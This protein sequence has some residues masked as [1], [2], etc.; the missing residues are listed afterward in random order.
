MKYESKEFHVELKEIV[1]PDVTS[2]KLKNN[3]TDNPSV[4]IRF[5][6]IEGIDEYVIV[7]RSSSGVYEE[8]ATISGNSYVDNTVEYG[9]YYEYM[10]LS[11][12]CDLRGAAGKSQ[13][14]FV[15]IKEI[16][17]ITIQ[18]ENYAFL[19]GN[20][21]TVN[22]VPDSDDCYEKYEVTIG[23]SQDSM[24][25]FAITQERNIHINELSYNTT[26]YVNI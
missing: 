25:L 8:L 23:T 4:E 10:V 21:I 6:A 24:N 26:Y 16:G 22:F 7:R 18:N 20:E 15:Q 12:V 9:E 14:V 11:K 1:S 5:D 19:N 13:G 3:N 17:A 2:V